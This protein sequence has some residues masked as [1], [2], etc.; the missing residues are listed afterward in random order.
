[1]RYLLFFSL[2][3]LLAVSCK[4][5]N[6]AATNTPAQVLADDSTQYTTIEW[7]EPNKKFDKITEGQMLDVSFAFKNTGNKPLVIFH[8]QPSCGCT[9]AEPPKEPIAPGAEGVIQATFNSE[10]RV[11]TQHKTLSVRANTKETQIHELTFE[12]EVVKK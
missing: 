11:G 3:A 6:S 2:A 1:M 4:F 9:A 10:G 8:V 5:K 12:V 7:K